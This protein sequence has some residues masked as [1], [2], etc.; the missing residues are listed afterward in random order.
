MRLVADRTGR[1]SERPHYDS[2]ELDRESETLISA[3]MRDKCGG[4]RLPIPTDTLTKL[5]EQEADDLDLYADLSAEGN[6]VQGVTEFFPDRKPRV[7]IARE[8]SEDER[9][10]NRLR[11]TLSH[12]YGHV[13]FHAWLYQLEQPEDDLFG[14]GSR[15]F[16]TRCKRETILNAPQTDWMEW[17]A[18]YVCGALLMPFTCV[19]CLV[20]DYRKE[21]DFHSSIRAGS[22][23]ASELVRKVMNSFSVSADA[24]RVRLLKLSYLVQHDP[25][26]SLL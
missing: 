11:T 3:F 10:E 18:G 13:R 26:P 4:W 6:D 17:Q 19:K 21:H 24:A 20:E 2:E 16:A 23:E 15:R 1:F 7:R 9:R 25:G 14:E 8:L 22:P 5:I 12:E